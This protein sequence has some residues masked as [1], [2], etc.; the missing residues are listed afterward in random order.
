MLFLTKFASG[1]V[2]SVQLILSHQ[3]L[4]VELLYRLEPA[5]VLPQRFVELPEASGSAA[6]G[7][8]EHWQAG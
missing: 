3:Q 4:F 8:F 7:S 1:L 6:T 2:C 5:P